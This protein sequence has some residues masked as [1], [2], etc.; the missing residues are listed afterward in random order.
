MDTEIPQT[1]SSTKR[2]EILKE[3]KRLALRRGAEQLL[4]KLLKSLPTI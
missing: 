4:R 1:N 2:L 3:L